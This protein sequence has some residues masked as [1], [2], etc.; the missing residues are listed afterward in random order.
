MSSPPAP[1]RSRSCRQVTPMTRPRA[2][3]LLRLFGFSLFHLRDALG[4]RA[5]PALR[6]AFWQHS[7]QG[8][9]RECDQDQQGVDGVAVFPL[10]PQ[11]LPVGRNDGPV[12]RF[13][14][15][16]KGAEIGR[17]HVLTPVNNATLL[18]RP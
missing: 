12:L 5:R 18:R 14:V 10:A 17:A 1:P 7:F 9:R 3:T 15:R 2:L 16:R 13:L 4:G 6:R 11:F 8:Q